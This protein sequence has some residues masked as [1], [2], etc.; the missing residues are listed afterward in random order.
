[1]LVQA[2]A[3][4]V[5]RRYPGL[6]IGAFALLLP[7]VAWR[8]W[9]VLGTSNNNIRQWLPL[10]YEETQIYEWF[11]QHFPSDEFALVTWDGCTL[12]DSRLAEFADLLRANSSPR[13]DESAALEAGEQLF[14]DVRTGPELLQTLTSAPFDLDREEALDRLIGWVIGKDRETTG[15][16]VTLTPAGNA[17]RTRVLNA[18]QRVAV[19]Q[20]GIPAAEL[21][22]VGEPIFNA[23]I[24]TASEQAM[25][26]L[27]LWSGVIA[28][29][30]AL[31]TLRSVKRSCAVFLVALYSGALALMLVEVTGGSLNLVLVVMPVLVYLLSLSAAVHLVNY[32]RDAAVDR[33]TRTPAAEAVRRGFAPCSLAAVTTAIGLS[34]LAVSHI[35]PVRDFGLYSALG[36]LAGLVVLFLLL[37]SL[38][39]VMDDRRLRHWSQEKEGVSG[40]A[41][42][43]RLLEWAGR[44][45]VA[46]HTWLALACGGLLAAGMAGVPFI[47]TTV[48][49][50]RFF[51]DDSRLRHDYAWVEERF[52][53]VSPIEIVVVF[54]DTQSSLIFLDRL[55]LV[56][57]IQNEIASMDEIAATM[58]TATFVPG[59]EPEEDAAA[60]SRARSPGLLGVLGRAVG[61]SPERIERYV[62]NSRLK[63]HHQSFIEQGYLAEA[64]Q[65]QLYRI[66]ARASGQGAV[67][68][69][70]FLNSVQS[71]VDTL[72]DA[73][74]SDWIAGVEVRYTGMVPLFFLAQRELLE[75]L[76]RSFLLAFVLIAVLMVVVLR[77]VGGGL[78][79]MLPNLFP[80]AVLF[81]F[82]GHF[83]LKVDIGSMLTASAAMGIAVDDTVH[84]LTWFRRGLDQSMSRHDAVLYGWRRCSGAMLQ[85]TAIGGLGLAVYATSSFQP[86][87][88]FGLLIFL[89]L[90][91]ALV[92]DLVFLPAL[93]ASPA[94]RLFQPRRAGSRR[95]Q[96]RAGS[97]RRLS[98]RRTNAT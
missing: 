87:A 58:S 17:D 44:G 47:Q 74:T 36:I 37:P 71:R 23:Q 85:T 52:G 56:R 46:G 65:K 18:I 27:P 24:D 39:S 79:A 3:R 94:G 63:D 20:V 49:P 54:D 41:E 11:R 26:D 2:F 35:V 10:H 91:L 21:H 34:S 75:G 51:P 88:Q 68:Q 9:L 30:A 53:P 55:R 69:A 84:F 32:Y 73:K 22:M 72:L 42:N 67:D 14:A 40:P 50:L 60:V 81:G 25:G 83:A 19:E 93:L 80:A 61:A 96:C 8:A 6:V 28:A 29:V 78:L 66:S 89:L 97:R 57:E 45:I 70:G 77:S 92:G 13:A 90:V 76:F 48:H 95:R 59:L 15:A 33:P 1:V 82:M 7:L 64:R 16:L 62:L 12:D 4:R 38:L 5:Y 31:I 43:G 86:I 98:S